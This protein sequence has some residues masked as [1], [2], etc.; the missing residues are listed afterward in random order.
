LFSYS[1]EYYVPPPVD[2]YLKFKNRCSLLHTP[3]HAKGCILVTRFFPTFQRF[4]AA[5]TKPQEQASEY[6]KETPRRITVTSSFNKISTYQRGNRVVVRGGG[7]GVTKRCRLSWLTLVYEPIS[8]GGGDFGVSANEYS[9]AHGAQMNFEDLTP[10]LIIILEE[11]RRYRQPCT[12]QGSGLI[13]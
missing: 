7:R 10:Y 11:G 13:F 8:G 2:Q 1:T 12:Q 3:P 9:C 5:G 4:S 6:M